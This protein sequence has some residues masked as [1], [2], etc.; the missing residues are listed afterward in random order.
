MKKN[1]KRSELVN[2]L[3]LQNPGMSEKDISMEFHKADKGSAP[4][5]AKFIVVFLIRLSVVSG[6]AFASAVGQC[7]RD[8]VP[9][10]SLVDLL[11]PAFQQCW[12][13]VIADVALCLFCYKAY[14]Y[15]PRGTSLDE[16]VEQDT[17]ER[18]T[19]RQANFLIW[20]TVPVIL[21]VL[22]IINS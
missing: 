12:W 1:N 3:L 21:I 9:Y 20:S 4:Y 17:W 19:K 18:C 7:I 22:L 13:I 14:A 8:G 5:W 15:T 2:Q 11:A 16:V 10:E 6:L